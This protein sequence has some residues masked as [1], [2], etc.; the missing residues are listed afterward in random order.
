M[1]I[2]GE[3]HRWRWQRK[4]IL[5][6]TGTFVSN[7]FSS[8]ASNNG[9][10]QAL[11]QIQTRTSTLV[12]WTDSSQT[13]GWVREERNLD[14]ETYSVAVSWDNEAEIAIKLPFMAAESLGSTLWPAAF[15][16]AIL[17]RSPQMRQFLKK[18]NIMELGAG[19]G[20]TGWAMAQSAA[21][22]HLTDNDQ[23]IVDLLQRIADDEALPT[24][25][26]RA[27]FLEWRDGQE[28]ESNDKV[29]FIFGTGVAYYY[30]LL[31]PLMDTIQAYKRENSAICI[32]GQTNR[33][34]QWELYHNIK[35]GCYN[36]LTDEHEKPWAG[37]TKMLLYK[38]RMQQWNE[39]GEAG[40]SDG[41]FPLDGVVPIAALIY[42]VNGNEIPPLTSYDYV[43]TALEENV[44]CWSMMCISMWW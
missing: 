16:G 24:G 43:A 8:G 19:L 17:G 35:D 44:S 7:T 28:V 20:L 29:D 33:E 13:I 26:T 15:A 32:I 6:C 1:S 18:K 31:R 30:Y 36:Q 21:S 22:C 37:T 27:S 12:P 3:P 25:N 10:V 5:L 40:V 14:A 2:N 38:L 41:D 23:D 11:Q 42:E 34:S 9:Y 39:Q 4:L